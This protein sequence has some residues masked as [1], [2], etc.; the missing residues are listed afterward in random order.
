M[1]SCFG[2]DFLRTVAL[3]AQE[4]EAQSLQV[5]HEARPDD[6][7]N[8]LPLSCFLAGRSDFPTARNQRAP[9]LRSLQAEFD[10]PRF[11]CLLSAL[12]MPEEEAL[13]VFVVKTTC[14][15]H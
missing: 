5:G 7:L 8:H 11:K 1:L 15:L 4:S 9:V 12:K 14:G 2:I 13:G 3:G 10:V 6:Y